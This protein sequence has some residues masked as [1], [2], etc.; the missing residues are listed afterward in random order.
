MRCEADVGARID[1]AQLCGF[2]ESVEERRDLGAAFR[3]R[4]IVVFA[5]DHD[6]AQ[7]P[8]S[9]V[10][11]ERDSRVFKEERQPL[12]QLQH[13]GD[14]L[15]HLRPRQHRTVVLDSPLEQ[16]VDDRLGLLP[17]Q[18]ASKLEDFR[19]LLSAHVRTRPG[20]FALDL[21]EFADK[22]DRVLAE[23]RAVV[24]SLKEFPSDMR[25]AV[26]ELQ[27]RRAVLER[28]IRGV[29]VGHCGA[30]ESI[31]HPLGRLLRPALLDAIRGDVVRGHTPRPPLAGV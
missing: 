11:V 13:V 16:L 10:V 5:A 18:P 22:L 19:F 30:F 23:L 14:G 20:H 2:E 3:P 12:P 15:A 24:S 8:L 6:A 27:I 7:G 28:L 1:A 29:A 17:S 9:R 26:S 25:P 21:E 31:E 4:A